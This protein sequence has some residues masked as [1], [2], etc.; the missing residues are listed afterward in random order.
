MPR[1]EDMTG[2]SDGSVRDIAKGVR[3]G[4]AP[5]ALGVVEPCDSKASGMWAQK[6]PSP[7]LLL[8]K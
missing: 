7:K 3:M 5:T 6:F 8:S 1:W 4:R 2:E